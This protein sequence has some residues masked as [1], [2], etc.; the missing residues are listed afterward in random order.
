[1]EPQRRHDDRFADE[2]FIRGGLGD[3]A[4]ETRLGR[5][6]RRI[7]ATTPLARH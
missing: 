4:T 2:L 5:A 1:M 3:I 6:S 7:D